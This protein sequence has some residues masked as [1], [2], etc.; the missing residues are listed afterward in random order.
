MKRCFIFAAGTFYGLRKRPEAGDLVIAA[1][2]G[3]RVCQQEGLVPD[4]ILGDFDSMDQPADF[5]NVRRAPVEK[6]DTDTGHAITYALAHGFRTLVLTCA[7]GGRL[8]HTLANLQ[9]AANAA[10][11]GASVTILDE[12]SEISFLTHGTLRLKKRPGWG[13]SVFSLSDASTGVCLRGVKYEL[14][15]AALDNRFPLG[16][17]NEFDAPEAE[18]TVEQGVLMVM[19][20]KKQ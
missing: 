15:N 9:N 10:V 13:L 20:K 12:G 4:V 18:I 19:Q 8:D 3:Y 5:A 6:D 17:S 14:E 11:Q 16:V 1:D 7:L 2:A